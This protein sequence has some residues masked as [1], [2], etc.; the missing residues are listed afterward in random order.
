VAVTIDEVRHVAGLA[1]LGLEPEELEKLTDELNGILGHFEKL[2]EVDVTGVEPAFRVLRRDNVTRPDA[3]GAMLTPEEA[4]ANAP[5]SDGRLFR[6]PRFL[7]D[8]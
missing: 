1:R 6:V 7:P 3:A 5:D 8:D 4:L 2:R